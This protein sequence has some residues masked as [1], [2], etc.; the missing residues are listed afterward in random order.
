[1]IPD[2]K[3]HFPDLKLRHPP[4][5]KTRFPDLMTRKMKMELMEKL[6]QQMKRKVGREP[7]SVFLEVQD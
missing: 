2:L 4:R 3:K 1:M 6:N 7:Y 5:K